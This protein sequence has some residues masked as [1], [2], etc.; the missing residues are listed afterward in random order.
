MLSSLAQNT[1]DTPYEVLITEITE[2]QLNGTSPVSGRDPSN[3]GYLITSK[4]RYVDL[5]LAKETVIT[6][7]ADNSHDYGD[8]FYNF[9][10]NSSFLTSVDLSQLDS[11]AEFGAIFGPNVRVIKFPSH[12][13]ATVSLDQRGTSGHHFFT[14]CSRLESIQNFPSLS[15]VSTYYRLFDGCSSLTAVDMKGFGTAGRSNYGPYYYDKMFNGCTSLGKIFN[16]A[17]PSSD[18]S[19]KPHSDM[20]SG[21]TSLAGGSIETESVAPVWSLL[22]VSVANSKASVTVYDTNLGSNDTLVTKKSYQNL[23]A[24]S[25]NLELFNYTDELLFTPSISDSDLVKLLKYKYPFAPNDGSAYPPS[26]DNFVLWAKN[27]AKIIT[28]IKAL[29]SAHSDT[30]DLATEATHATSADS[31]NSANEADRAHVIDFKQLFT[32]SEYNAVLTVNNWSGAINLGMEFAI[33]VTSIDANTA[34]TLKLGTETYSI[35]VFEN[36]IVNGEY[37]VRIMSTGSKKAILIP[38][39][40]NKN[41]VVV[42]ASS[43]DGYSNNYIAYSNGVLIQWGIWTDLPEPQGDHTARYQKFFQKSFVNA[44]YAFFM[45]R[46]FWNMEDQFPTDNNLSK[47][48]SG[49]FSPRGNNFVWIAGWHNPV[50]WLA[51]G[52]WY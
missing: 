46:Q 37:K 21:C 18:V 8:E 3:I 35:N 9:P 48:G 27:A 2:E 5:I 12:K 13:I 52:R 51:L 39:S 30:A 23:D 22:K 45:S 11:L 7:I 49:S 31:A 47:K 38:L 34:N 4:G 10:L 40:S 14:G 25:G 32:A 41:A 1:V 33:K 17:I 15:N 44:N 50:S 43:S 42:V 26:S 29:D 19:N 16:W 36:L 28:N 24:S 20:F 6:W